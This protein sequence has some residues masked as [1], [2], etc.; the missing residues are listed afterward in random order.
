MPKARGTKQ[1]ARLDRIDE[2]LR[3]KGLENQS[4]AEMTLNGR[5]LGKKNS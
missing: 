2:M 1:K 3:F 4:R 5:R